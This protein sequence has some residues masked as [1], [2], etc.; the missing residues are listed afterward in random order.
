MKIT[1]INEL[2]VIQKKYNT[3]S[4]SNLSLTG[5]PIV[6]IGLKKKGGQGVVFI[7]DSMA[8]LME[9]KSYL[10]S[11]IQV[12]KTYEKQKFN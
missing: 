4:I 11:N 1:I 10:K 6:S 3:V 7:C 5:C 12:K 9:I 8:K 2:K